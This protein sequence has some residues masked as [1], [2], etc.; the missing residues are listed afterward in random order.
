MHNKT[1]W[2]DPCHLL[3]LHWYI[4]AERPH[5]EVKHNLEFLLKFHVC[6]TLY[7]E[8]LKLLYGFF[9]NNRN[10]QNS[11]HTLESVLQNT[12]SVW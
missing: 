5:L 7:L 6:E 9:L 12:L 11:P 2:T 4:Q 10:K 1:P 8:Q 3:S